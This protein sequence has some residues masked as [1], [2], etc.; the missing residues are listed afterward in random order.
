MHPAVLALAEYICGRGCTLELGARHRSGRRQRARPPLRPG[1]HAGALPRAHDEPDR[2]LGDRR[3]HQGQRRVH[4]HPGNPDATAEPDARGVAGPRRRDP[5]RVP[6]G[7]GGRCGTAPC[8]TGTI[9]GPSPGERVVFHVDLHPPRLPARPRLQLRE[10]RVP[11]RPR[12]RSCGGCSARTSASRRTRASSTSTP[13]AT[14][15]W[16]STLVGSARCS[17]TAVRPPRSRSR[18]AAARG[19]SPRSWP[20][21]AC[22]PCPAM[23][24]GRW[25][26]GSPWRWWRPGSW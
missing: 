23:P 13:T 12:R 11:R 7:L 22:G 20:A 17:S 1:P 24:G 26:E 4:D 14:S 25:P 19:F 18:P 2:L 3:V 9:R 15:G 10:R 5:G 6:A 16:S 8:G 21:P